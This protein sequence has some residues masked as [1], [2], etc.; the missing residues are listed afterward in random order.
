MH[1]AEGIQNE[2]NIMSGAEADGTFVIF[3]DLSS[4]FDELGKP[5]FID[6]C[7]FN[8]TGYSQVASILKQKLTKRLPQ[9]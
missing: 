2:W 9:R 5:V 1:F 8:D 6:D 3:D 7:H 4:A